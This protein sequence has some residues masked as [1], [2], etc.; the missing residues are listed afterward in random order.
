MYC[1]DQIYTGN[2]L[3]YTVL[4]TSNGMELDP[5]PPYSSHE[6]P[7]NNIELTPVN[8][9]YPGTISLPM[10]PDGVCEDVEDT[11]LVTIFCGHCGIAQIVPDPKF[12]HVCG[13]SHQDEWILLIYL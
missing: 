4:A 11:K 12:C 9:S 3:Q 5:A 8:I 10:Q 7:Q 2:P 6:Y 13:R 1:D